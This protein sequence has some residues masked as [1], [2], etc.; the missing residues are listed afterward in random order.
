MYVSISC[1]SYPSFDSLQHALTRG[2]L[3]LSPFAS[4]TLHGLPAAGLHVFL[5]LH[6]GS[7][8]PRIEAHFRPGRL[9]YSV[10]FQEVFC[11]PIDHQDG[12]HD[13]QTPPVPMCAMHQNR[14]PC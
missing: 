9:H 4:M 10:S 8:L 14:P 7:V 3:I 6:K 5:P 1:C 11:L 13:H 12:T 2:E